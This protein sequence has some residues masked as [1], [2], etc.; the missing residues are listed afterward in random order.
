MPRQMQVDVPYSQRDMAGYV[1]SCG[2]YKRPRHPV[3]Q[4]WYAAAYA[5]TGYDVH[6]YNPLVISSMAGIMNNR[7]AWN[8]RYANTIYPIA[9]KAAMANSS[10]KEEDPATIRRRILFV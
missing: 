4:D 6:D 3:T 5:V 10:S 8:A 1:H 9:I 7:V 2:Y